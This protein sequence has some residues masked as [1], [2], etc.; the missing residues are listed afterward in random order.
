M[1][2]PLCAAMA[3]FACDAGTPCFGC[4]GRIQK[5]GEEGSDEKPLDYSGGFSLCST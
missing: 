1:R 3:S 2:Q 5:A 4:G